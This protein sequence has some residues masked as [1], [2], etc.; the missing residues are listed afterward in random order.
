MR[1]REDVATA[2][3]DL[4]LEVV[5]VYWALATAGEAVRVLE[6]A[7]A[8]A[9]AHLRDVRA[10]FDAGLIP[11][12]DVSSVEA[13]RSREELQLI[14]ARNIRQSLVEDLKRLTGVTGDIAIAERLDA[15]TSVPASLRC[16]ASATLRTARHRRAIVRHGRSHPRDRGRA[17]ADASR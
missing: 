3:A 15:S 16:A 6:E 12:N 17:P 11:P 1:P 8:R 7:V 14:E 10:Q 5:R 13:Q 4:R 2:R 9:D